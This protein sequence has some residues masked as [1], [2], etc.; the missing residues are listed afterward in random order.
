MQINPTCETCMRQPR[1]FHRCYS[2]TNHPRECPGT[3]VSLL[4]TPPVGRGN[5]GKQG[6]ERGQMNKTKRTDARKVEPRSKTMMSAKMV[7]GDSRTGQRNARPILQE[8]ER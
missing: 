1:T 4:G 3:C 2:L 5:Q 8:G 7:N 6:K